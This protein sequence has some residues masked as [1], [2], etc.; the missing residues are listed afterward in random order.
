VSTVRDPRKNLP[1]I[2]KITVSAEFLFQVPAGTAFWG[3]GTSL[4]F[5]DY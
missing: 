2:Q 4:V 1:S 5:G 3:F